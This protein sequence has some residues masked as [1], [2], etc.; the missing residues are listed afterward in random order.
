MHVLD[1]VGAQHLLQQA[2]ERQA[3]G[4]AAEAAQLRS[5]CWNSN[6]ALWK[7]PD[8]DRELRDKLMEFQSK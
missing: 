1:V 3:I 5:A 2:L 4:A 8:S 6:S 7:H